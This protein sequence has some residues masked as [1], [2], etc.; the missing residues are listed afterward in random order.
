MSMR[1]RMRTLY[2]GPS[3]VIFPQ[4]VVDFPATEAMV[5]VAGGY[6]DAVDAPGIPEAAVPPEYEQAIM[7][8]AKRGRPKRMPGS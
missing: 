7:P 8:T 4:Q 5:L 6:A 2:A 3:G 1:I